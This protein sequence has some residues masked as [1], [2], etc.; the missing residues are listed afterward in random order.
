[1]VKGAPEV[2]LPRCRHVI[3]QGRLVSLSERGR[4]DIANR[5]DALASQ[6]LRVLAI[7]T[8]TL[9][10]ATLGVQTRSDF[11]VPDSVEEDLVLLGLVGMNDPPRAE[12]KD[13]VAIARQ[14]HVRTVMI[15]GDHPA[16]AAAIARELNI[17][18]P[19]SRVVTGTELRAMDDAKLDAIVEDARVFARVDPDHKLRIV[20]SLQRQGHIAAMTGDGINDAPAL[21]TANVGIAMGI[22]GT[23]VSKEAADIV[24]TDDNYASIVKA[25][26]EGRGVYENIQKY[27][28]YLLS[29]NSGELMTMFAGVMFATWLGLISADLGLFLPLLAAQ[30]LWINLVTDGPPALALGVDPKDHD[31]MRHVPRRHGAGILLNEDW[32]R[33]AAVGL[34]MMVGTVLVLDARYPAACSPSSRPAAIPMRTTTITDRGV[35]NAHAA[36]LFD[37]YLPVA[38]VSAFIGF[39]N[40]PRLLVAIAIRSHS[41]PPGVCAVLAD[42]F[43]R[44]SVRS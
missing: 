22:T 12:V 16:T 34:L 11:E 35:H 21:K 8:R 2:L 1:M 10:A 26:G 13:A 3:E 42:R 39:F 37:V 40:N 25:I 41:Y 38:P 28:L 31:I 36:P 33:L 24:L 14:A 27:L 20:Q 6:A 17:L 9:P 44:A 32:V 29:T 30:L 19:G 15:T 4:A 43:Q 5:N 7:A 18:E 23:D